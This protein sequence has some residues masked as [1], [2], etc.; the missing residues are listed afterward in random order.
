M[1]L[2]SGFVGSLILFAG[3]MLFYGG[4][5]TF[6]DIPR[7]LANTASWR[8][9]AGSLTGPLGMAFIIPAVF[10]MWYCQRATYPHAAAIM[11][12]SLYLMCVLGTLQHGI[13]EPAGFVL[14]YAGPK[15]AELAQIW[16]LNNMLVTIQIAVFVLGSVIWCFLTFRT[17]RIVPRWTI[18]FC[19]LLTGSL[20]SAI[21]LTPAPLG[22][23]LAGG[24]TLGGHPKPA[25][26][27]QLKT[28]QRR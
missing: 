3:D 23:P 8:L 15:G 24:W 22:L 4:W 9:H 12:G 6:A 11:L 17:P 14:R 1:L 19:P 21:R 13:F 5:G 25:N 26:G 2:W 16:R 28:G 7:T 20:Q 10:G 18:L 27:G